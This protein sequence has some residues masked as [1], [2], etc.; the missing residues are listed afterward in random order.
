MKKVLFFHIMRENF[1]GAQ[2]N[3]FRLLKNLDQSK[4][5]PILVGQQDSPLIKKTSDEGIEV[6]VIPYPK[7]LRIYEGKLLRFNPV[8]IFKFVIGLISYGRSFYNELN[9][10]K[11]DVVWC[12]NIRTF[13]TL[14]LPTKI[15]GA[16][17]IWNIWSEPQGKIAWLL[18]RLGFILAD[19][20]NL[21]YEAQGKKIFGELNKLSYFQ[22][23]IR[24][25]YTG[26]SD[27]DALTDTSIKEELELNEDSILLV[28]A[29]NIDPLKGQLDIIEAL[30]N[31][32]NDNLH[33]A[34]AGTA[35][36]SSESANDYHLKMSKYVEE[37]ALESN[38][39]FLGWRQDLRDIFKNSD[40]YISSSYSESLPDAVREGMLAG[41]PVIA[42]DVGGTRE[43]V[44]HG[45]TGY[46][47]Q[48]GD[49]ADLENYLVH[50]IN[51]EEKRSLMG[52]KAKE[53]LQE[54]FSNQN[55]ARQFQGMTEDLFN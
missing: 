36:S 8:R 38:V 30:K 31:M 4:I 16:K 12:D 47:I 6:L 45:D 44:K 3:I 51:D 22:K 13:I 33:L 15:Y 35:V 40:I 48:P 5:V 42:T 19:S 23:K 26:V 17:I 37:N 49:L 10:S 7:E 1:S 21:E 32:Q 20:I 39:H 52:N 53:F 55:Y 11:P 50:L 41:L 25:L 54:N 29:S 46:L 24:T 28:M 2:K 34:I 43:L 9:R 14:Y 18:H 27:F